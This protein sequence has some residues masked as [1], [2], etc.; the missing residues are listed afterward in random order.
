MKTP[1]LLTILC[2]CLF[3]L[4][5]SSCASNDRE[6]EVNLIKVDGSL[7]AVEIRNATESDIRHAVIETFLT[8]GYSRDSAYGL[9]FVK[10]G[11]I[12]RQV[13]YASYMGGA[14]QMRVQVRISAITASSHLVKINADT[15]T[16]RNSS[17]GAHE[18]KVRGLRKGHYRDLLKQVVARLRVY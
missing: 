2:T 10:K 15:V 11:N 16:H 14:A 17:F 13:E 3:T 8:N 5:L 4:T 7:A 6:D 9:T 1:S 12:F 18:K